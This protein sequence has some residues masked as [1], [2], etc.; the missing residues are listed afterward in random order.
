[1]SRIESMKEM[2]R[3]ARDRVWMCKDSLR[4]TP[5]NH[6]CRPNREEDLKVA[7]MSLEVIQRGIEKELS[8]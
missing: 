4:F 2:E 5:R 3:L 8:Q 6:V 1:M 7:K